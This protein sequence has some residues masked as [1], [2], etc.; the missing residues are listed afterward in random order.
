MRWL[1]V[2]LVVAAVAGLFVLPGADAADGPIIQDPIVLRSY[3]GT[4]IVATLMLPAGAS[5]E[6]PVPVILQTHGWGGT[7][8]RTIGGL[9]GRLLDRGYAILTWDSPG[10]GDSPVT[11]AFA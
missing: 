10:F 5:A 2:G 1:R 3:D 8:Q 4:P 9:V 7:R 11:T 6:A